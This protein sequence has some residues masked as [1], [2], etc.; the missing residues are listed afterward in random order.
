M[1]RITWKET[2]WIHVGIKMS[3]RL[4]H[5]LS[6]GIDKVEKMGEKHEL[7]FEIIAFKMLSQCGGQ[8]KGTTEAGMAASLAHS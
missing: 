4:Y 6:Y 5:K 7:H 1:V 2:L 8:R 3:R